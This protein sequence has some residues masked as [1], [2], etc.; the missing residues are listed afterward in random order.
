MQFNFGTLRAKHQPIV[1]YEL[2]WDERTA[3]ANRSE[4]VAAQPVKVQLQAQFI[5]GFA[6]VSGTLTSHIA[7]RCARCLE[8][9]EH[10][11]HVLVRE[12]FF[13]PSDEFEM[14]EDENVHQ[15]TEDVVPFDSYILENLA[16]SIPYIPLCS[17]QCKG[18]CA[19]CGCNL[20]THSCDCK[21]ETINPRMAALANF[22]KKDQT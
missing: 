22:F 5:G 21:T 11:V 13:Q 20:N 9:Y 6:E 4:I 1:R 12:L 15:V 14:E 18:L 16:V 7:L 2:E 8:R 17:A 3:W 10:P 19:M